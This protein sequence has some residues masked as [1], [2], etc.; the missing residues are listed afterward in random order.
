MI[1]E[2]LLFA[3][4]LNPE[5]DVEVWFPPGSW[6]HYLTKRVIRGPRIERWNA[7]LSE[8]P[9]FLREGYDLELADAVQ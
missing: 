9:L 3:P 4:I 1:G 5:G 8:I 2:G 7:P 6:R